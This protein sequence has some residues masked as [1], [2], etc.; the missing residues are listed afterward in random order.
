MPTLHNHVRAECHAVNAVLSKLRVY[1]VTSM[2]LTPASFKVK[3][4]SNAECSFFQGI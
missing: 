1:I 4:L 3:A 2:L